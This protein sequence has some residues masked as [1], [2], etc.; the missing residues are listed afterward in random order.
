MAPVAIAV[1]MAIP[2]SGSAMDPD[3]NAG[4]D[5]GKS[6]SAAEA[7]ERSAGAAGKAIAATAAATPSN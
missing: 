2:V 6:G 7:C 1:M 3:G 4:L 5:F